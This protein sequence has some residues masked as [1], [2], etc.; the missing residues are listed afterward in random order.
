MF[1]LLIVGLHSYGL[2]NR[3]KTAEADSLILKVIERNK[4][5]SYLNLEASAYLKNTQELDSAPKRFLGKKV[6][7]LL[8]LQSN[9]NQLLYLSETSSKLYFSTSGKIKEDIKA[10]KSWGDYPYMAFEKAS[11]LQLNFNNDYVILK[12]LSDKKFV[13]PIASN[14]FHFYKFSVEK[15]IIDHL[16]QPISIIKIIPRRAFSPTFKGYIYINCNTQQISKLLLTLGNNAGVSFVRDLRIEQDLLKIDN[17]Y[18]PSYTKISYEGSVLGF[19]FN[20]SSTATFDY[21][22]KA[23]FNNHFE[24][25]ELLKIQK[26]NGHSNEII[27]SARTIPLTNFEEKSLNRVLNLKEAQGEKKFLD[28]LDR[29]TLKQRLYP[30]LFS[31]FKI[32]NS[33]RGHTFTFDAI[34]PSLFYNTIEGPG[35][36]YGIEYKNY[37]KN[38]TNWSIKPEM[39]YG[40]KNKEFNSDASFSWYYNPKQRAMLNVSLGSTY[41]DLNPNGT[42]SSLGNSLNTL[43]FEQ[44]FMKLY[45]KKYVSIS[46]GKEISNGLYFSGGLD[47][48]EN[49]SLSNNYNYSLRNIASRNFTSNNPLDLSS[50]T[51]LF[52][53][54]RSLRLSGSLVYTFHHTYSTKEG[55]KVYDIPRNPRMIFSYRKGIPNVFNS[56]TNYDF[57]E[58]EFQQEKM[59]LGL[60][61]FSS[62]SLSAGSFLRSVKNYYPDWKHFKGNMALVYNAGLKTFHLLDF[63]AYSTDKEFI[64]AHVEHNFQS[65]FTSR[66]PLIRRLKVNEI[67]GGALLTTPDK[68][69]YYELYAGFSRIT[70]RA[71]YAISFDNDRKLKQGF[72]FSYSF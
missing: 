17:S 21:E 65:K 52:P 61:G 15:N 56:E 72:K 6:T 47:Y 2:G 55:I 35:I 48:S 67:I 69:T 70:V 11:D 50:N 34:A 51:K 1:L 28:S 58:V 62:F 19:I 53:D 45:R 18:Y 36:K 12:G 16:G 20:G 30:L 40:F 49:I 46:S 60:W 24:P 10:F 43:L 5:N 41:R 7:Q 39:R 38:G 44:N 25:L 14:A 31:K 68:G 64:E 3:N 37:F 8:K 9:K 54:H 33:Y 26:Q 66:I 59:D 13:S 42:L 57:V 32:E 22:Q 29:L 23:D 4:S 71:D 63:Y 27:E